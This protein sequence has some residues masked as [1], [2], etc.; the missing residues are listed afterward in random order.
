MR[1]DGYIQ[2]IKSHKRIVITT[3]QN[4]AE[5]DQQFLA[6]LQSYCKDKSASLVV[7]PVRY[8]AP[9]S[10]QP[11]IAYDPLIEPYCVDNNIHFENNQ[12]V[13][14]GGLKLLA[15]AVNPLASMDAFSKGNSLILGHSQYQLR[16][17]ARG[18]D[19]KYPPIITTTGAVTKQ[20]Y[21]STKSGIS[22]D[23]NHSM[24]AVVV[25]LLDSGE[26]FIRQLNYDDVSGGFC[27]LDTEY[28]G[29]EIRPTRADVCVTGDSHVIFHDREVYHATY[30]ANGLIHAVQPKYWV[31][32]DVLDFNSRS[33]HTSG[34]QFVSY[35]KHI[36]DWGNVR[37]EIE[38][39]IDFIVDN[40]PTDCQ[41]IVVGSNH[42]IHLDK[43]LKE[44][45]IRNDHMDKNNGEIPAA[46][47]VYFKTKRGYDSGAVRFL[48]QFDTFKIHNIELGMHGDAGRNGSRGSLRQFTDM[49]DKTVTAHSHSPACNKGSYCVG[50]SSIFHMGYVKS[51]STW[52]HAHC[53]IFPNGKRQLV[54]LR[55]GEFRMN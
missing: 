49:P 26:C 55:D 37:A 15:T 12:L 5:V 11:D 42:D 34:D 1:D 35:M 19:R 2:M 29:H 18:K 52:D 40:R 13:I 25:E 7:I 32:H 30:G 50:T 41:A 20:L 38:Q 39:A 10:N 27:D 47:G 51:A 33:H 54:F 3:A 44:T 16:T 53:L 21:S 31:I 22:A 46:L 28:I 8:K 48:K 4:N 45:D 43:W 23:F 24:S 6:T 17:L 9:G 36:K 14:M